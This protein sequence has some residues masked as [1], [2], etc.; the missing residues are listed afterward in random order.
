M[1]TRRNIQTL[2]LNRFWK[3]PPSSS[4]ATLREA[5]GWLRWRG[6]AKA[7]FHPQQVQWLQEKLRIAP[8][9]A[10]RTSAG[11]TFLPTPLSLNGHSE[12]EW[13]L[14]LSLDPCQG[15]ASA[16]R[17]VPRNGLSP[18]PGP[19]QSRSPPLHC[20]PQGAA[21]QLSSLLPAERLCLISN[22]KLLVVP[23]TCFSCVPLHL[24]GWQR[25]PSGLLSPQ[26]LSFLFPSVRESFRGTY[27]VVQWLRLHTSSAGGAG[28]VPGWGTKIPLATWTAKERKREIF[29]TSL[30]RHTENPP[31]LVTFTTTPHFCSGGY[32]TLSHL[33]WSRPP[34]SIKTVLLKRF[35]QALPFIQRSRKPY[36]K[37]LCGLTW[38]GLLIPL[39]LSPSCYPLWL[40]GFTSPLAVPGT[41]QAHPLRPLHW[42]LS[43]QITL[44]HG[45]LVSSCASVPPREASLT[46]R[47]LPLAPPST[48]PPVTCHK[49][50][51]SLDWLI[52][53]CFC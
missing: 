21:A 30:A 23:K 12:A 37:G 13:Q 8:T 34:Q 11:L 31:T 27:R 24:A 46:A 26:L 38:R 39:E 29:L 47:S 1:S 52:E 32:S 18:G 2:T 22:T 4:R 10:T 49:T 42:L 25:C 41:R 17:S 50:S 35:P 6:R 53:V 9:S 19:P 40:R 33:P 45:S 15:P 5:F 43:P 48:V 14:S 51:C 3:T 16:A 28:S 36:T 7:V 44:L 20:C